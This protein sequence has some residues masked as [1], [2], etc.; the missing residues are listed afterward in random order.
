[1]C[2]LECIVSSMSKFS[3]THIH[4]YIHHTY[5]PWTGP[6]C[7]AE[8]AC[9]LPRK[10][11]KCQS[12]RGNPQHRPECA[13]A[14]LF[15][16]LGPEPIYIYIYIYMYVC[17]Y[18]LVMG[19]ALFEGQNLHICMYECMHVR[20]LEVWCARLQVTLHHTHTHTRTHITN[21]YIYIY[22]YR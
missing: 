22:I 15:S 13:P 20:V 9:L 7:A 18:V 12:G 14:H 2:G 16:F 5:S 6:G 21:I 11:L 4:T 17:M 10:S 1:M 3:H 19:Y 8:S